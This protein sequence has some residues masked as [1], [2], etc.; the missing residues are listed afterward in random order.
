MKMRKVLILVETK[1]EKLLKISLEVLAAAK[2][3]SDCCEL[4]VIGF[5]RNLPQ[6]AK[7]L[8]KH[9]ANKLYLLKNKKLNIYMVNNYTQA[10]LQVCD[11]V[12]PDIILVPNTVIGVDLALHIEMNKE[13]ELVT[14]VTDINFSEG[15]LYFT[16]STT[17]SLLNELKKVECGIPLVVVHKDSFSPKEVGGTVEIVDFA[18]NIKDL[19]LTI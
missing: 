9:G 11:A 5:D 10:F 2:K 7:L 6:F 8:A 15:D 14:N 4:N 17:L 16:R 13:V 3:I 1:T 12:Q 18:V 19:Q